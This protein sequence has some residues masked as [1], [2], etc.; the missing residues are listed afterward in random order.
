MI[1][2]LEKTLKRIGESPRACE[3]LMKGSFYLINSVDQT[4]QSF[5]S[6]LYLW[7]RV[8]DTALFLKITV[9]GFLLPGLT[10]VLLYVLD[11]FQ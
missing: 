4:G 2:A 7:Q 1:P 11:L 6:C 9:P 8:T 10:N 5:Q 3:S